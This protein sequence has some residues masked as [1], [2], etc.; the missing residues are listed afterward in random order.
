MSTR[1]SNSAYTH[2]RRMLR[3]LY[4]LC[5]TKTAP[6]ENDEDVL[7]WT[8]SELDLFGHV[9]GLQDGSRAFLLLNKSVWSGLHATN[10]L[11]DIRTAITQIVVWSTERK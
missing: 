9:I 3:H 7:T 4:S 10:A 6:L 2:V 8:S 11:A 1:V 5:A